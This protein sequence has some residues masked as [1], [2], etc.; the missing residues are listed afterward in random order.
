[1]SLALDIEFDNIILRPVVRVVLEQA[2]TYE[3][4]AAV[5]SEYE[6]QALQTSFLKYRLLLATV[7]ADDGQL[8]EAVAILKVGAVH[9]RLLHEQGVEAGTLLLTTV[10]AA[11]ATY[12]RHVGRFAERERVNAE[13][14][15]MAGRSPQD[16]GVFSDFL[17]GEELPRAERLRHRYDKSLQKLGEL[18]ADS[19]SADDVERLERGCDALMQAARLAMLHE[20]DDRAR[21]FAELAVGGY[22][23]LLEAGQA[24]VHVPLADALT[25]ISAS[26]HRQALHDEARELQEQAVAVRR[27][28]ALLVPGEGRRAL[29]RALATLGLYRLSAGDAEAAC[30][31]A[32]EATAVLTSDAADDE[33]AEVPKA[34]AEARAQRGWWR[35]RRS[36]SCSV[37]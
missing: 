9:G 22:E 30:Q 4:K 11:Q 6:E 3:D 16:E 34:I 5:V 18:R 29:G 2:L 19:G 33:G 8:E 35:Q 17:E 1:M 26:C 14:R 23:A 12:L 10:L 24:N 32:R 31:A 37:L 15:A 20:D 13:L 21:T 28:F 25:L 27:A 7:L 36:S